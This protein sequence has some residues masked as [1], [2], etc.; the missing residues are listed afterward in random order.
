LVKAE[1]AE[2]INKLRSQLSLKKISGIQ[3]K[4][5]LETNRVEDMSIL[6]DRVKTDTGM[7]KLD[8]SPR[9][10]RV[11]NQTQIPGWNQ[12]SRHTTG[13]SKSTANV[14]DLALKTIQA[15]KM[16]ETGRL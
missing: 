5:S 4:L 3:Q 10:R 1:F 7:F 8:Q 12:G 14:P 6:A 15:L 13:A 2:K 11:M 9:T 16:S